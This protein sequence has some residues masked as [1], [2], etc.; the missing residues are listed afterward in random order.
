MLD[1]TFSIS[2]RYRYL[3]NIVIS[4]SKY[5]SKMQT[6]CRQ[7]LMV[8]FLLICI[9]TDPRKSTWN[10]CSLKSWQVG[11]NVKFNEILSR[12]KIQLKFQWKFDDFLA[13]HMKD[14]VAYDNISKNFTFPRAIWCDISISNRYFW[15]IKASLR[16]ATNDWMKWISHRLRRLLIMVDVVNFVCCNKGDCEQFMW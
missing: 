1:I 12:W 16:L 8:K 3:Q 10:H 14:D 7:I 2:I 5:A 13:R 11:S 4:I 9:S 15:Y 6:F